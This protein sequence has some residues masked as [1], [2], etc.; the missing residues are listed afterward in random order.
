MQI[1][2]KIW[3]VCFQK[4]EYWCNMESRRGTG[5]RRRTPPHPDHMAQGMTQAL[6]AGEH[7]C[8]MMDSNGCSPDYRVQFYV[9]PYAHIWSMLHKFIRCFLKKRIIGVREESLREWDFRNFKGEERIKVIKKIRERFRIFLY[10]EENFNFSYFRRKLK[11][12]IFSCL[13]FCFKISKI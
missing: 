5:A 11:F 7:L 2:E 9:S 8:H 4:E 10:Q 6:C 13:K 3:L 12:Y 1:K